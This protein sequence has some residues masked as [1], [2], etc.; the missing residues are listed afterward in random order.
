[1]N[2]PDIVGLG[3]WESVPFVLRFDWSSLELSFVLIQAFELWMV[4]FATE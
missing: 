2:R 3:C 4:G 1:M